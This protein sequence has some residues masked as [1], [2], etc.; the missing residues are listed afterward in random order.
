[1]TALAQEPLKA[2]IGKKKLNLRKHGT[3]DRQ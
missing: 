1:M 2:F 3:A